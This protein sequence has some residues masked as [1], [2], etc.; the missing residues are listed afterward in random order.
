MGTDWSS[1]DKLKKKI[2]KYFVFCAF[3]MSVT[4]A[5]LDS[6]F[7][8]FIFPQFTGNRPVMLF[9][10]CVSL[11]SIFAVFVLF[12]VIFW[13]LTGRAV[14][15]ES[16]RQVS[17][18]NTQYSRIC[19]DLKTPMTSVQGFAAALRDGKIRPE[20]RQEIYNIIYTKS[21]YMNELVDSMFAYSKLDMGDYQLSR[22]R[23][24][25]C[26]LVRGVVA[27]H[28]DEFENRD[29]EL[30]LDIPDEPLFCF[31]DEKE[32]KR[33]IG[34]LL[35]N[36]YK[37]NPN[38]A[39]V[40]VKVYCRDKE[41]YVLVADKGDSI[42]AEQESFI[43]EPFMCGDEARASGSGNGLGLTLSRIIVR[44]HGGDLYIQKNIDSYTK[45]F[46]IRI[47]SED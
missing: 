3:G 35:V 22:K 43:F 11:L 42:P 29:M 41:A 39:E 30:K 31:L 40:M 13:K 12:A 32:M 6:I 44:K 7:T 18:R 36:A 33:S 28:Y 45:G 23:L 20:E 8:D 21:C 24:D 10:L 47:P 9:M 19:H 38:R 46:I 16:K 34:N 2:I 25:L 4:E 15:E 26:S 14:N 5:V 37:H 27:L 1:M 17:E